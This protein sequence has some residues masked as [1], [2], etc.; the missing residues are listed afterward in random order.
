MN[1]GK[2]KQLL[3]EMMGL[4]NDTT[5]FCEQALAGKPLNAAMQITMT[6]RTTE[7][8]ELHKRAQV[9]VKQQAAED[10]HS[11]RQHSSLRGGR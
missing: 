7:A 11:Q 3:L 1:Y 9:F 10:D 2:D 6:K 5:Y 8:R 4:L